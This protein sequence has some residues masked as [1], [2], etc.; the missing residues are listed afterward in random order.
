MV[1]G[2]FSQLDISHRSSKVGFRKV[3][4]LSALKEIGYHGREQRHYRGQC[5][6]MTHICYPKVEMM[7]HDDGISRYVENEKIISV[8][9]VN[10]L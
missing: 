5:N 7:S 4:F 3:L 2:L 6:L 9:Q 10:G 8:S 1:T